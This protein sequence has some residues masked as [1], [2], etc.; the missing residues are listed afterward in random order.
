M[1]N[2]NKKLTEIFDA[3]ETTE[4][5][6]KYVRAKN[7]VFRGQIDIEKAE[8]FADYLTQRFL[9]ACNDKTVFGSFINWKNKTTD[10][11]ISITDKI[12]KAFL[13]NIK[14]DILN[15]R[16]ELH[17]RDGRKYVKTNDT[18][19]KL[20]RE[21]IASCVPNMKVQNRDVPGALM[22][23]TRTGVLYI[24]TTNLLYQATPVFFLMDLKHELTHVVDMYIQNISILDPTVN[25]EA[26]MF[27]VNPQRDRDLYKEN[28]LELNAN[29]KRKDL[30]IK[31]QQML[32]SQES[33]RNTQSHDR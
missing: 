3:M 11:K 24:N 1:T 12:V 28:P 17:T 33:T 8:K 19:D 23:T 18:V 13:Q 16:V 14:F 4:K 27:Y 6:E 21:D 9:D 5:W 7:E 20:F 30:R 2:E 29:Q 22:G 25:E 10:E 15:D 32:D 31:I 26:Q